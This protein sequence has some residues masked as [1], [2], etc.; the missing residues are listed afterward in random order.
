MLRCAS[1]DGSAADLLNRG[2]DVLERDV[3]PAVAGASRSWDLQH[4]PP[5]VVVPGV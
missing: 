5:R 4:V 1:V 2:G 3:L